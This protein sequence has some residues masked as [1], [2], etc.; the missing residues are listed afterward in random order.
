MEIENSIFGVE[1]KSLFGV[2]LK[3]WGYM[4]CIWAVM[5]FITYIGP[6][7]LS[8]DA[9]YSDLKKYIITLIVIMILIEHMVGFFIFFALRDDWLMTKGAYAICR[10]PYY[11]YLIIIF[12]LLFA[13]LLRS[14]LI[15]ISG[16]FIQYIV[17]R[18]LI[19]EEEKKLEENFGQEYL[20][21]KRRVNALFPSI[22][23]HRMIKKNNYK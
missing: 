9:P 23:F 7:W 22:P 8:I 14:W 6:N 13:L 20:E 1:I 10:N 3:I 12:P 16:P 4:I 19:R 18:L 15:L 11:A 5:W 17:T 21:Y 2:G